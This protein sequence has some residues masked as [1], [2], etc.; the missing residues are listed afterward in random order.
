MTPAERIAATKRRIFAH[1]EIAPM[2]SSQDYEDLAWLADLAE[3][4]RKALEHIVLGD[5]DCTGPCWSPYATA[6]SAAH[7]CK[8]IARE[9]LEAE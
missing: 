5:P 6:E 2:L 1:R 3:R 7:H 8:D 4:Y 9:H